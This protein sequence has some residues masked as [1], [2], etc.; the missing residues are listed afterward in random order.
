MSFSINE[1]VLFLREKGS[2]VIK[3]IDKNG[4]YYVEDEHGFEYKMNQNDLIKIQVIAHE[5]SF[6]NQDLINQKISDPIKLSSIKKEL[7]TGY[8]KPLDVWEIDLHIENIIEEF[9]NKSNNELLNIQLKEL[10]TFFQRAQ[11]K[12]IR[13]LI[14]IH[15]V[16]QGVLREEVRLFLSKLEGVKFYDADFRTYGRGATEVEI[17]YNIH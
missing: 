12:R 7:K 2:G 14:V 15:G 9:E 4:L 16:G 1:K 13:K 3:S 11:A 17:Y 6:E 5:I 10:K 8:R